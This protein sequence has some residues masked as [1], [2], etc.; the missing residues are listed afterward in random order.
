MIWGIDY[1][2]RLTDETALSPVISVFFPVEWVVVPIA[3]V[4]GK[5]SRDACLN[6]RIA[7]G[8]TR[9]FGH[10]DRRSSYGDAHA[11]RVDNRILFGVADNL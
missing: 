9:K 8:E 4:E 7:T 10:I 6:D 3:M 2:M 5:N 11:R 1:Y